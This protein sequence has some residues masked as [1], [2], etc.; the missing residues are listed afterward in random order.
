MRAA[1]RYPV[2]LSLCTA[3]LVPFGA[4]LVARELPAPPPRAATGTYG[5]RVAPVQLQSAGV[6]HFGPDGVLF[7]ADSRGGAVY[8]LDIADATRDTSST[9]ITL[10]GVD[11]QI[12]AALG[13]TRDQIQIRDMVAHPVSQAVYFSVARGK[14]TDAVPVIVRVAKSDR[15]ITIVP[16]DNVR[17]SRIELKDTPAPDAKTPWGESKR[18]L[19]ITHLALDGGELYIAGLSNEEFSSSLRRVAYPVRENAVTNTVEIYHTS[20]DRW[21]TASPIESILPI[22]LR[23][24]RSLVAAYT[25]SPIVVFDRQ[26]LLA[27]HHVRGKT[28]AEL[29]GGNR[30][31]DMIRYT[32]PKTGKEYILIANS[33]RT[34]A[35]FDPNEI[36]SAPEMRTAVK[37]AYQ[38]A[39]VSYLP[40]ATV[41]VLQLDNYNS[42]NV[43]LLKRDI[44]T[45]S[46]DLMTEAI[47]WF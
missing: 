8:A 18:Q 47:D 12:A 21:E 25:C 5:M 11:E 44:Q 19:A 31:F 35:R 30:P 23:G 43:L 28:V 45:G 29:G 36:G 16:L 32:S 9:G 20:H 13:T 1:I 33:D 2:F 46:L 10:K 39:G 38:P 22:T 7:V 34:L 17:H 3:S 26:D 4:H 24:K 40:V 15:R 41:G 42:K 6:M 37:Q 14:G 27:Q